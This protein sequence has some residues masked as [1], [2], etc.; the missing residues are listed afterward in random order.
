MAG[1]RMLLV[2]DA[3]GFIDPIF[4]S[5]VMIAL[6]AGQLAARRILAADS[7]RLALT[8]REQKQYTRE[9]KRMIGVYA[10]MIHMFYSGP[11][12]EIFIQPA[13]RSGISRAVNSIVAGST[14]RDFGLWWRVKVFFLFCWLQQ[15]FAMAPRIDF[16]AQKPGAG[17][18]PGAKQPDAM[19]KPSCPVSS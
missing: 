2:G 11:G 15:W 1:A 19:D 14:Q 8:E 16:D 10:K 5:G 3:A 4:S 17:G 6:K 12:F 18:S 9:I 13:S 7:R